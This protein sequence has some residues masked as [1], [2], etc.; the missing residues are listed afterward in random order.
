MRLDGGLHHWSPG[1][2]DPRGSNQVVWKEVAAGILEA[3]GDV[4]ESRSIH[5]PGSGT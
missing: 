3:R 5:R 1:G 4:S 2:V